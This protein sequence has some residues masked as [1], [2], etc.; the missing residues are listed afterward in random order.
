METEILTIDLNDLTKENVFYLLKESCEK[1]IS[2][3]KVVENCLK[4]FLKEL[5][6][7]SKQMHFDF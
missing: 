5:E 3:N 1:D 4:N 6:T 7:D 2:V